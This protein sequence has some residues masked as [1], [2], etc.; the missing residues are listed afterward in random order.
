MVFINGTEFPIYITDT[1]DSILKRIAATRHPPTLPKYLVF[2]PPVN[3]LDSFK[4]LEHPI[5][6]RDLLSEIRYVDNL[7]LPDI[8]LPADSNLNRQEDIEK[9]FIAYNKYLASVTQFEVKLLLMSIRNFTVDKYDTWSKREAIM[10]ALDK[11]IEDNRKTVTELAQKQDTF[12]RIPTVRTTPFDMANIQL[13]FY[14]GRTRESLSQYFDSLVLDKHTP[15]AQYNNFYKVYTEFTPPPQWTDI[16]TNNVILLKVNNE[17][18]G[19]MRL[20]K[21][22]YRKYVTAAVGIEDFELA[23]TVDVHTGRRFASRMFMRD[24]I[25]RIFKGKHLEAAKVTENFVI[26]YFVIPNQKFNPSVWA[27]LT[28]NHP[29]FKQLVVINESLMA[30]KF[31]QNIYIHVIATKETVSLQMKYTKKP[32]EIPGIDMDVDTPYVRVRIANAATVTAA[33]NVQTMIAKLVHLYNSEYA[34]VI[35]QY[36]QYIP[37]FAVEAGAKRKPK[38]KKQVQLKD[39]APDLFLPKYSRKCIY[40]PTIISDDEAATTSKI[41]MKFPVK[42]EGVTRNYVCDHKDNPYPGLRENPLENKDVYRFLPC[43]YG[44]DQR[45]KPGSRYRQYYHDEEVPSDKPIQIQE[46]FITAKILHATIIGIL[47]KSIR[48]LFAAYQNDP[49]FVFLRKGVNRSSSTLIEAVMVAKGMIVGTEMDMAQRIIDQRERFHTRE[50]AVAAK[51]EMYDESIE[52]ILNI[53]RN[54]EMRGDLFVHLVEEAFNVD[55]ILF[56]KDKFLIPPHKYVYY[57]TKPSKPTV[58]IYQHMGS[59]GDEARYPQCE[60]IIKAKATDVQDH[61]ALFRPDDPIVTGVFAKYHDYNGVYKFSKPLP[62]LVLKPLPIISQRVDGFGKG[63]VYNVY[64]K[65]LAK[66][67]TLVTDPLPPFALPYADVLHRVDKRTALQFCDKYKCH[68]LRQRMESHV[69]RELDI[70]LGT[71][72]ATILLN[73]QRPFDE[74]S[75]DPSKEKFARLT[76]NKPSTLRQFILNQ[77]VAKLLVI[78][79]K[80]ILSEFLMSRH[81]Y[82]LTPEVVNHFVNE[83]V[84]IDPSVVYDLNDTSP[85]ITSTNTFVRGGKLILPSKELLR[86]LVFMMRLHLHTHKVDML[87][88]HRTTNIEEYFSTLDDFTLVKTQYLFDNADAV[89]R[90]MDN[91]DIKYVISEKVLIEKAL[92]PYFFQN[93]LLG[94]SVYLA[95]NAS[96]YDTANAVV[97]GWRVKKLNVAISGP[98]QQVYIYAYRNERDMSIV[99][100][101]TTTSEI[102]LAYKVNNVP[103]YTVLMKL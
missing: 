83:F 65:T 4:T 103:M 67:V 34:R 32:F 72:E 97:Y 77:R 62:M 35:I 33:V 37:R 24:R 88:F 85:A 48:N 68:M 52:A 71:V 2:D 47:P 60:L 9:V 51:Q 89:K 92:V 59:E 61:Q 73:D 13:T 42:D 96:N 91:K 94:P 46:I 1:F 66:I 101:G 49:E 6:V 102:L 55:I 64:D 50:F 43:C 7:T 28:M 29:L 75:M 18:N 17:K 63:R 98:R 26:G 99:Q 93:S 15:F 100:E 95:Q 23:A 27:E 14:F 10:H 84:R 40:R 11:E 16:K 78:Y 54:H 39:I 90:L 12:H 70:T 31:K 79:T 22:P 38:P 86:R 20:L 3:D 8:Q 57:K 19:P 76:D 58:F 81:V 41:V 25:Q 30:S 69:L 44:T 36:R 82:E 21:D 5:E 45:N 80:F 87:T 53:I 56:S 74:V